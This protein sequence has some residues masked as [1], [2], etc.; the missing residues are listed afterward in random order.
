[1]GELHPWCEFSTAPRKPLMGKE[2]KT[3]PGVPWCPESLVFPGV[4]SVEEA[5]WDWDQSSDLLR[6]SNPVQLPAKE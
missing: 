3:G 2:N 6:S 4:L 5:T 1:M